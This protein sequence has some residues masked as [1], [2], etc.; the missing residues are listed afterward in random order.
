MPSFHTS[1][2]CVKHGEADP[3]L[4]P[5]A[6]LCT[7]TALSSN[8]RA[9]AILASSFFV[10]SHSIPPRRVLVCRLAFFL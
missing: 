4:L 9:P 1:R 7:L 5:E 3:L 2:T 6:L 8:K 10:P